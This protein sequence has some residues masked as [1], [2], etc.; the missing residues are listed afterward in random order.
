MLVSFSF[1][2]FAQ[3][4]FYVKY[5]TSIEGDG[6]DADMMVM[7]MEGST[8]EVASDKDRTY[9]RTQMGSMMTMEL[10]MNLDNNEMTML[11]SGMMGTMA[12]QGDPDELNDGEEDEAIGEL[13]LLDETKKISGYECSKA[14][15][16]DPNG[17]ETTYWYTEKFQRP[18]GMEQ[19]PNQVP[20]LSL[21]FIV[22]NQG[23]TM[24][25]TATLVKEKPNMM[26]YQLEIPEDVEV[27]T[28]ED[29]K[30]LGM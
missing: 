16:T 26:D 11:M 14:V 5:E 17:A 23:M 10:E 29:L 19:L 4:S 22:K 1:V 3:D 7:M 12:F 21:E 25:Y 13:K 9:V 28:L 8:M 30:N 2:G 24:K 15:L 27:K 6:E 20:G 18:E